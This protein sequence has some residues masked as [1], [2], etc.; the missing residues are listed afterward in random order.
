MGAGCIEP[1]EGEALDVPGFSGAVADEPDGTRW[2]VV[3]SGDTVVMFSTDLSVA[4]LRIVLANLG[5]ARRGGG[6]RAAPGH[7][8]L[9]HVMRAAGDRFGRVR[10]TRGRYPAPVIPERLQPMLD[11]VRPLAERFVG[12]GHAVYLVG[13]DRPRPRARA[14]ARRGRPRPDHRRPARAD[15]GD[16][17]RLGRRRVDPG[18]GVRHDRR[19]SR[20]HDLRDHDPSG[21]GLPRGLAQAPRRLRRRRRPRTC[22]AATS[23]STPWRCGC[24]TPSWSTPTAASP[25][26]RRGRLR[27]PL[28]PE[29]S[30]SDDPLRMIRAA[31]FI[32]GLRP[33]RPTRRW[34]PPSSRCGAGSRSCRPSA[35]ATSCPSCWWSTIPA[36]ACGSWPTPGCPTSSCP[37]CGR[38][39]SSRT[40]STGT[41]TCSPTRSRWWPRRRPASCVRL[42]ALLHDVGKPKT[43]SIGPK[44]V[45]FHH[46]EVVGA[47]MAADRLRALRYSQRHRST[48]CGG[49]C[50]CT[51]G[52]TATA[53]TCGATPRCAATPATPARC[54]RTSTS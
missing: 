31:R 11:D 35:S 16:A 29:V 26:W 53:T 21:R 48:T 32:A 8:V 36:R 47:R 12:A 15:D 24:P 38:C 13:R 2:G 37:S 49:W 19:P 44:G 23:R 46:H 52:S 30:F 27:T 14:G 41:R 34:S 33:R 3:S 54:S 17:V 10:P 51:C 1:P 4:D 22:P 43:R 25:T 40:R 45:S 6:A 39:A 42:A 9:G 28:A 5:P 7:P 18:A 50:S 20:R